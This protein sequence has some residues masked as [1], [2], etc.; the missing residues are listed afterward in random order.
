MQHGICIECGALA[1]GTFVERCDAALYQWRCKERR[2]ATSWRGLWDG[3]PVCDS[4]GRAKQHIGSFPS[5]W[6]DVRTGASREKQVWT[7]PNC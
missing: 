3:T 6:K 1:K 7:C 5:E 4:C 2:C